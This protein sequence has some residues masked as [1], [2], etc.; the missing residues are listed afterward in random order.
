MIVK[1]APITPDVSGVQEF[2]VIIKT[3]I[4][5]ENLVQYDTL[6]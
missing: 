4:L 2:K 3:D 6:Q 5:S 1:F